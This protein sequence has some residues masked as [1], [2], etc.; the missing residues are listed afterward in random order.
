MAII[1]VT[2]GNRGI[3]YAIV[4]LLGAR[5]ESP[6]I[7]IGCRDVAKGQDAIKLLR[8]EG[9]S[10]NLDVVQLDI[11]DDTSIHNAASSVQV[12]YG[13]LDSK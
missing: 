4:K 2:G 1:L 9:V 6:T 11:E 7:I 10:A 3:G 8:E 12:K 13:R 5:L